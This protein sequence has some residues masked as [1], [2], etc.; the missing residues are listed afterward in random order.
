MPKRI[1]CLL[2]ALVCVMSVVL[3]GCGTTE[4]TNET[5]SVEQNSTESTDATATESTTESTVGATEGTTSDGTPWD[6][7]GVLK[8]LTIGNSFSV[9]CMEFVYQIAKAAG[10]EKIK[11]GN[12]YISGCSLA[13]HL[14]N[15]QSDSTAY[16]FYT[17]SSGT[18]ATNKNYKMSTAIKS[19]NWDF[20]SFQQASGSSGKADTYDTLNELLPIVEGYCTNPNVEFMWHM[21]WAYQGNSTH[22]SFPDYDS[23]QMTMYNAIVDAVK[24]KIVPNQKITKIVPNGTAVQNARTSYLGDTLTRDGYHMSKDKGRVLAG[25]TVVASTVGIPWDTIDLS[26]VCSD[27]NFVKVALESAKNAVATPF[28]VTQ[29][30]YKA[31]EEAPTPPPANV[32]LSQYTQ[33]ILTFHKGAYY[34][35]TKGTSLT[36]GTDTAAK[37]F[38]TDTFTKETLPVGSVIVIADGWKYRPEAWKGTSKTSVAT[39]PAEVKT[40]TIVVTEKWWSDWTTRGF[41]I[42]NGS[43]LADYTQEQIAEVFQIYIPK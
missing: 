27:A 2:L 8:I 34:N 29:S 6:D 10:V 14:T 13:K 22:A 33:L 20:V 15:A 12:L 1:L 35:S 28:A 21:T 37:Y 23:D 5:G 32:D 30:T 40:T 17:N 24:T 39:R 4:Q 26:G 42:T 3:T 16:T 41:N 11:L 7:D 19:D 31:K 43:S 36:T 18:W 9:D 25:I 38:A